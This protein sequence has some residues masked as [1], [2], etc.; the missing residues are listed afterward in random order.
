VT[1]ERWLAGGGL[2]GRETGDPRITDSPF[3]PIFQRF[4]LDLLAFGEKATG[5]HSHNI[6]G[7]GFTNSSVRD[8]GNLRVRRMSVEG[9]GTS[10]HTHKN[11]SQICIQLFS[12]IMSTMQTTTRKIPLQKKNRLIRA[13]VSGCSQRWANSVTIAVFKHWK[14][15]KYQHCHWHH[16]SQSS[17]KQRSPRH[18]RGGHAPRNRR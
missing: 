3:Y 6:S 16:V 4:H 1:I 18:P 9:R 5:I 8:A 2:L 7:T 15:I 12:E 10:T 11:G 17:T 14:Y 13:T